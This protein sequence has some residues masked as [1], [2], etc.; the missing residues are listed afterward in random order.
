LVLVRFPASAPL[1]RYTSWQTE[2]L[3]APANVARG[4]QEVEAATRIHE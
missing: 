3:H 1:T 4:V 2:V